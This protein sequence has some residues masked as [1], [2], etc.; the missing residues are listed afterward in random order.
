[1]KERLNVHMPP[2]WSEEK[3]AKFLAW[4]NDE[5]SAEEGRKLL[6]LP[7]HARRKR[8]PTDS[9]QTNGDA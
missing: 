3:R 6:C 9:N 1:M 4:L 8:S 2:H 5:L 7:T